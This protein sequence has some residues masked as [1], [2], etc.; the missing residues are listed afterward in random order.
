M[1]T[2]A[3]ALPYIEFSPATALLADSVFGTS[4]FKPE[5]LRDLVLKGWTVDFN[6]I[7]QTF[8]QHRYWESGF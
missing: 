6:L 3:M 7:E 4:D 2:T 5:Q 8:Q 1:R